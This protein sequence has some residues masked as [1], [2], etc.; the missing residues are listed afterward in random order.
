[1]DPNDIPDNTS[2]VHMRFRQH[3]RILYYMRLIEHELPQLVAFRKPFVPPPPSQPL[4]IRSIS[5][6]GEE[7][8]ATRKRVIVVPIS[9]LP[10]KGEAAIHKFKLLAGPRWS[11]EAPKD[12]GV[13]HAE[14]SAEHG[15]IKISCE[16]F[17]EPAM[18][19]KWASDALDR[20]IAE[21]NSTK[22]TFS[23]VPLDMRHLEARARKAKKG[24]HM[25]RGGNRPSIKDFPQE[26][27]PTR[28]V[29]S[30]AVNTI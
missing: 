20:L 7:H 22:D 24:G 8:P 30:S 6:G 19:L 12:S 29:D 1:M 26:W 28:P 14:D 10:L 9:R 11:P 25:R 15:Y 16:D 21:A 2:V 3:R 17:P 5:Y 13:G 4:V 18:N 23:D 27:L